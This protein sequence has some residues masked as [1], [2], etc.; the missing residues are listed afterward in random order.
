MIFWLKKNVFL[1]NVRKW[2]KNY[3]TAPGVRNTVLIPASACC[4]MTTFDLHPNENNHMSKLNS[5][6]YFH[7][8]KNRACS[9]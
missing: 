5:K 8:H 4:F 6:L 7:H 2:V 1:K 9:V 3:N